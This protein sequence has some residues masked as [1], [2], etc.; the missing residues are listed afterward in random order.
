[1]RDK[2]RCEQLERWRG[3]RR[4]REKEEDNSWTEVPPLRR[5]MLHRAVALEREKEKE[6]SRG[7]GR[8][9]RERKRQV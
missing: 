3:K 6:T 7:T 1:M 5:R 2:V 8:E 4:E 9:Y